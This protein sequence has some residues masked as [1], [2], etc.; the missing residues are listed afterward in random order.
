ME[1]IEGAMRISHEWIRNPLHNCIWLNSQLTAD[2]IGRLTKVAKR[3]GL[4]IVVPSRYALGI[5]EDFLRR[6][7]FVCS[8]NPLLFTY[9]TK[10]PRDIGPQNSAIKLIAD[11]NGVREFVAARRR[12]VDYEQMYKGVLEA[13]A[14]R[15]Y[16][17]YVDGKPAGACL[18]FRSD[19][20][21][22]LHDLYVLPEFR[23]RGIGAALLA[24][25]MRD[26]A[27]LGYDLVYGEVEPGGD[28]ARIVM[29]LGMQEGEQVAIWR[30]RSTVIERIAN[31]IRRTR[32]I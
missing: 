3:E 31:I 20:A 5:P 11:V 25:G 27:E 24:R 28:S 22:S 29:R 9:A 32:S 15:F 1:T 21:A 12:P 18:L 14:T 26:A 2:S 16:V 8:T 23:R 10:P 19:Y 13:G 30:R 6:S 17:A 4:A 7:Q